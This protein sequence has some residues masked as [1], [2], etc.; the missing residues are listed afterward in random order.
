MIWTYV[1]D[2]G[3]YSE[4]PMSKEEI[5]I[6]RLILIVSITKFIGEL[7]ASAL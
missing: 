3:V 7:N 4:R 2:S 6:V 1:F 5:K